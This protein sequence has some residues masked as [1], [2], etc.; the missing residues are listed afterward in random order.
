MWFKKKR[1]F[2]CGIPVTSIEECISDVHDTLSDDDDL[3][4]HLFKDVD[5]DMNM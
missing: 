5:V 4:W 3:E 1:F 2:E